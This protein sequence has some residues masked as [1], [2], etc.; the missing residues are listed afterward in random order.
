MIDYSD[1]LALVGRGTAGYKDLFSPGSSMLVEDA[2]SVFISGFTGETYRLQWKIWIPPGTR[3]LQCTLYTRAS[4]P[5]SK[6]LMRM[7]QPPTGNLA[8]V[9]PENAAAVNLSTVLSRLLR[10][11][12][13]PCYTPAEAG[14][15]KLSDGRVDSEVVTTTGAWLYINALQVPGNQI[16]KLDAYLGV[17]KAMYQNWYENAIWDVL[18]NPVPGVM[19]P[20]E[21][22]EQYVVG[23][24]QELK[25]I[26]PLFKLCKARDDAG[27][28]QAAKES[29]LWAA[30]LK[31]T[32]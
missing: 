28:I 14:A 21:V 20:V 16:Y 29:G 32:K 17:D 5:E 26:E 12:E 11:D 27:L 1:Y 7:H 10:G 19:K 23:R 24:L 4:P 8:D 15:V 3:F 25:M 30:L 31:F 6:V 13:I 18:D 2:S 22:T 9:T